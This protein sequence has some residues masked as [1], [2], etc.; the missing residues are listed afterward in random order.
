MQLAVN[1]Q[2]DVSGDLGMIRSNTAFAQA[3]TSGVSGLV[4]MILWGSPSTKDLPQRGFMVGPQ[5]IENN[6]D[7]RELLN[8]A[9]ASSTITW[10]PTKWLNGRLVAGFDWTDNLQ[11]TLYPKLPIGSPQLE[12]QYS[13]GNISITNTRDVNETLDYSVTASYSPRPKI[14]TS[15]SGG[16]QYFFRSQRRVGATGDQFPTPAVTTVSSASVRSSTEEYVENKTFGTFLQETLGWNNQAFLTAA[17]RAD[18][19]SAFGK[20]F[21]AAYYPK[22]SGT[23]VVSDASFWKWPTVN[24]FRLRGA[25]G[26]SG[27]QPDAFD[28]V[29]TWKP[30][31]GPN[32]SPAVTPDKL[33]N[34]ELK[35]EIGRELELGFDASFFQ[36]KI[37]TEVTHYAKTTKDAILNAGIAPSSGFNGQK[38]INAGEISNAGWEV[39]LDLAPIQK[40]SIAL[41]LGAAMAWNHN[42][43][44]DMNGLTLPA[45]TRGRW[46]HVQGYPVGGLWTQKVATAAWGG[47]DGK[48]LVNITCY[49]G[50][51][52]V[53]NLPKSELG[54]YP[55]VPCANAPYFFVGTPGPGR[56]GSGTASLTF[57]NNLTLSTLFSYIGDSRRFNTTEWYRDKTQCNSL[58]CVQMRQGKLDPIEAAGIQ[59]VGVEERWFE[60][61]D[62]VRMR[63]LSLSYNLPTTWVAP[64]GASRASLTLSGTN[65]W[66]PY[67]APSFRASGL[68]PEAKKP[69]NINYTW[70]Q[71]QA[72]LPASF[73][74]VLRVTF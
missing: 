70:Q 5:E 68:D 22:V 36:N 73:T 6:I 60:R 57:F 2:I 54:K 58:R 31:I 7:V 66:T 40:Q 46:Q 47:A 12:A 62:F 38:R 14:S 33:G 10:R 65:L 49:G 21:S 20:D 39:K 59:L 61:D 63:D 50:P 29:K 3:G 13:N 44:V 35:P 52:G 19:N 11:S 51:A 30:T 72:P 9:T 42:Q 41:N 17:L 53:K 56:T 23:W 4:P 45:D 16:I 15:T 48:T 64:I 69:S 55:N 27:Q 34:D 71:T 26:E 24:S 1:D 25:W 74:T 67:V 32:D 8:R 18:A 37:T 28:A 43:I